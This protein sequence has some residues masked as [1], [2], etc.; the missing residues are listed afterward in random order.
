[1]AASLG[2]VSLSPR[3]VE[4]AIAASIVVVAALNLFRAGQERE[5]L[6]LTFG[7][8]LV[9]GL[10]FAG[11]LAELGV[12]ASA[13]PLLAF[14]LGVEAGQIAIAA[15]VL[16]GLAWLRR[17]PAFLRAGVPASSGIVGALGLAWL[18]ERACFA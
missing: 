16:P 9:H 14:N 7:F 18:I 10:G 4:P 13:A 1:M 12:G 11:A 15:T 3:L 17:S 8:G 5:R 2:W 6:A